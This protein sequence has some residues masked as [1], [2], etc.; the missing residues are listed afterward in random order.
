M[1]LLGQGAEATSEPD[2]AQARGQWQGTLKSPRLVV[3]NIKQQST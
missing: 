1:Y 3:E 2:D